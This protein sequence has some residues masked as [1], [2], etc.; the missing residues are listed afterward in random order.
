[1]SVLL[2]VVGRHFLVAHGSSQQACGVNAQRSLSFTGPAEQ[3]LYQTFLSH[4]KNTDTHSLVNK[5]VKK[6]TY[7]SLLFCSNEKSATRFLEKLSIICHFVTQAEVNR[8]F[9]ST[10]DGN[11]KKSSNQ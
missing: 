9:L 1:L 7:K 5:E 8:H 6:Q 4:T 10:V 3:L 11:L 2:S